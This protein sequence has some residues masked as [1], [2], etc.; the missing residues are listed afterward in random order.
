MEQE[1]VTK[2]DRKAMTDEKRLTKAQI[3]EMEKAQT[4]TR[5]VYNQFKEHKA[6][7]LGTYTIIFFILI[8]LGAPLIGNMLGVDAE[9]QNVFNR[10]KPPMSRISVALDERESM[11]KDY[12]AENPEDAAIVEAQLIKEEFVTTKTPAD[13]LYE[14]SHYEKRKALAAIRLL[15]ID[16]DVKIDLRNVAKKFETFHVFGTDEL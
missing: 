13:A 10:Y 4:L 16:S 14:W 2:A 9:S 7:V 5:I 11:V 12:I 8:A 6:A 1:I 15:D 3:A